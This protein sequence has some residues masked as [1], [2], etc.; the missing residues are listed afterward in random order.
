MMVPNW[1][2]GLIPLAFLVGC[3]YGR[4]DHMRELRASQ[5]R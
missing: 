3:V 4:Y 1:V 2:V 5:R